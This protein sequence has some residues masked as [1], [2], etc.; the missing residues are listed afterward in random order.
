MSFLQLLLKSTHMLICKQHL[1]LEKNSELQ[2]QSEADGE[3]KCY[4]IRRKKT[5]NR[6]SSVGISQ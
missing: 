6:I 1:H 5:S 3:E 2:K 4:F